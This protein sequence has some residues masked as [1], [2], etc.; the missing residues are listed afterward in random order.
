M[1]EYIQSL[2]HLFERQSPSQLRDLLLPALAPVLSALIGQPWTVDSFAAFFIAL[3]LTAAP[4]ELLHHLQRLA[5]TMA[6]KGGQQRK[7]TRTG[8]AKIPLYPNFQMPTPSVVKSVFDDL[9]GFL[10]V[11]AKIYRGEIIRFSPFRIILDRDT[12]FVYDHSRFEGALEGILCGISA[13]IPSILQGL[14]CLVGKIQIK[15]ASFYITGLDCCEL[16]SRILEKIINR[17]TATLF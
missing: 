13:T 8:F 6:K 14:F 10:T 3:A 11:W 9:P 12:E 2:F 4:E 7:T 15:L 1:L 16:I 17:F 5:D